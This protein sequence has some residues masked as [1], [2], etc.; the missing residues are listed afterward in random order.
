[1][2]FTRPD[3]NVIFFLRNIWCINH[4]CIH[5]VTF[6]IFC[7][8]VVTGLAHLHDLGF[9]NRDLKPQ[10]VLISCE[11]SVRA[12]ICDQGIIE[13]IGEGSFSLGPPAI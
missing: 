12:K 2:P 6:I 7:R 11:E 3:F 4:I 5:S 13:G 1:M 10:N 8:D 9:V